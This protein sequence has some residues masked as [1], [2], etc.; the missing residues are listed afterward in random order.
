[1]MKTETENKFMGAI[2]ELQQVWKDIETEFEGA[3]RELS[4]QIEQLKKEKDALSKKYIEAQNKIDHIETQLQSTVEQL[5]KVSNS[6]KKDVDALKLLDIYLVLMGDVFNSAA[7]VRLL[8]ILHGEKDEYTLE[9]LVKASGMSGIEVRK[10]LF[11]LR[12]ANIVTYN[13][14][15]QTAKIIQRFL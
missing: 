6:T 12:N 1:M 7:H 15:T 4:Q 8:F 10:A 5:E 3:N 9:E 13:D 2:N 11:E 14:D